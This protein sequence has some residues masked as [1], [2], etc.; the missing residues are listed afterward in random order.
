MCHESVLFQHI[1]NVAWNTQ[2]TVFEDSNPISSKTG[3]GKFRGN[4][5]ERKSSVIMTSLPSRRSSRTRSPPPPPATTSLPSRR[6]KRSRS[7]SV[8]AYN[9]KEDESQSFTNNK[10]QRSQSLRLQIP[11]NSILLGTFQIL[12]YNI[13]R[14]C[15]Y[16]VVLFK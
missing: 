6:S 3:T 7:Q 5:F 1:V 16:V 2:N 11:E 15:Q 4:H 10:Q 9:F 14:K 12:Y 13:F 8:T